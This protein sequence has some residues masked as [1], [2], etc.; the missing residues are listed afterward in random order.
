VNAVPWTVVNRRR[1]LPVLAVVA[2]ALGLV[3]VALYGLVWD[4][5]HA[6]DVAMLHGFSALD[7]SRFTFEIKLI[8]RLPDPLPYAFAGLLCIGV[9]L[10]R[11]R[12]HRAAAV[13]VLLVATG[14]T[15]QLLKHGLATPRFA[16]WLGFYGQIEPAS[17]PSGHSTAAMTLAL[18][19]VLV[20]PPAVRPV[21]ALVGGA[22][23]VGVG[24]ATL[25]LAWHYPSDVVAG[26]LVAG[27]WVSLAVA[28]L[29]HVEPVAAERAP[30]PRWEPLALV[31]G[32]GAVVAAAF[33]GAEAEA[34][35]R[36]TQERT[37]VVAGALA[38]AVLA[39][40]LVAT[41]SAATT[42]GG[43]PAQ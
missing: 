21:I 10:W 29:Q 5:G 12:P 1:D 9:A 43:R 3:A 30:A 7:Q 27:L 31:G 38:I 35:A 17:W 19:A 37:T 25:A 13:A 34:I 40:S 42:R 2:C 23:A 24:Y 15:T 14:A 26:Y 39:L 33:V 28:V 4:A 36:Y 8:A 11:R 22:F 41:V 32:L 6:R 18:C 20:S 16:D